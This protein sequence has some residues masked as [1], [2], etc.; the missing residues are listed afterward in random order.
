MFRWLGALSFAAVIAGLVS[1]GIIPT[2]AMGLGRI[3]FEVYIGLLAVS[4]CI[5]IIW[6]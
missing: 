3:L 1:T 5:G 2:E 4:L 6:L